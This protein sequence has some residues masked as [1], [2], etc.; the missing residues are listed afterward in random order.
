[1]RATAKLIS[2]PLTMAAV[3]TALGF[4][5]IPLD[6]RGVAE[7]GVI[8]SGHGYI[9]FL[10]HHGGARSRCSN[11]QLEADSD[12]N[13]PRRLMPLLSPIAKRFWASPPLSRCWGLASRCVYRLMLIRWILKMPGWIRFDA[14]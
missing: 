13:G 9:A 10:E 5:A 4:I 6:H 3:M 14:F 1:M 7:L 2:V 8:A 12:I 11:R